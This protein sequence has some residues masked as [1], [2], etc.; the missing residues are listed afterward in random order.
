VICPVA[1]GGIQKDRFQQLAFRMCQK[2]IVNATRNVVVIIGR[3][4][5]NILE[6]CGGVGVVE[7][8]PRQ[9]THVL[10]LLQDLVGLL[11]S[12]R[13]QV[14]QSQLFARLLSRIGTAA[15][16]ATSVS[17]IVSCS[18]FAGGSCSCTPSRPDGSVQFLDCWI[19][20]AT[21]SFLIIKPQGSRSL[22]HFGAAL[23]STKSAL[24]A[25][26]HC[27]VSYSLTQLLLIQR[28]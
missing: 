11:G 18:L 16:A 23:A 2:V 21:S 10:E 1:V 26:S 9:A 7:N 28:G 6:T 5:D 27:I 19:Q 14:N 3:R 22:A 13:L 4:C 24:A 25:G 12:I 15:A 17:S 20:T 8:G